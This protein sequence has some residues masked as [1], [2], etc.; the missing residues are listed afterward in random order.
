VNDAR[1]TNVALQAPLVFLLR[2]SIP[3]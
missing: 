2:L 1:K 3:F